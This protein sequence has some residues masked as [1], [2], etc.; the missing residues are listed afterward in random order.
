M[1]MIKKKPTT[2][3]S[4]LD[5]KV[6]KTERTAVAILTHWMREIINNKLLDLGMPDVETLADDRL[7][8]DAVIYE[9]QRSQNVLCVI[10]AKPP[11]YDVFDERALKEPA[12]KKASYRKAKYFAVTNFK[13]L[14]WYSTEKVNAL[15]PEEEQ[16][17]EKYLLSDIE[18][19]DDI[20]QTRYSK[21]FKK[22]LEDFLIRLYSVHSGKEPE[23]KLAIDDFLVFRLHQKIDVL[24]NYYGK[25]IHDQCHKDATFARQLMNW[26]LDQQWSFTWQPGDFMKAARQAAYLLV[27]KILFYDLLQAKRPKDLDPLE[28]PE[29]RTKGHLL[30]KNLEN[31]FNDVLKIDY[32]SIFTSDF[33]DSIAFP[34]VYE[35][36]EEIKSLINILRRYDFS[37]MGYDIIGRIFE[38]LI[39]MGERHS[40]GQYF[41]NPDIVD[42]ILKFC[43]NHEDDRIVDPSCGAGTFLV[44][45]Y[46]H[47]KLTNERLSHEQILETL[48]GNDIAKFPAHLAAINL[49]INDLGVDKN[50]PNILQSDFFELQVGDHGFDLSE[51]RKKRAAT[52][53]LKEREITYPRWFNAVVGNPPYTRQEEIS[54]IS[55]DDAAYKESLIENSLYFHGKKIATISKRAGIHAYFFVHGTKFLAEGGYFGFIV[56]NSWLDVDYGKGL[57]EFFLK[58][59]KII[60]II[61]SKVERWFEQADINTCIVILQKCSNE[62]E[63]NEHLARFVYL[64]RPLRE[65]IP[66]AQD[67]WEKQLERLNQID[68][69]K[70]TI[71]AHNDFYENKE[72]RIFPK[73]QRDL[74]EEGYDSEKEEYVGAK[75]GKYLRAPEIFFK[76]MQKGKDKLIPLKEIAEVRFGIKTGANEFFYLTEEEIKQKGIEQEFWMHQDEK[77]NS[78]PNYI[79]KNPR[80][81]KSIF[82]TSESFDSRILMIHKDK[83]ELKGTRI[84]NYIEEGELKGFE[85]RPTC[86]SR[87]R[88]YDLGFQNPP[89][90][91]WFKAFNDRFL[92][93]QNIEHIFSSDRFY[94]IYLKDKLLKNRLFLYLNSSLPVLFVELFGRVNLGEG[95]LDNMTY[96]VAI[97]PIVDIRTV[98]F[99]DGRSFK[100]FLNRSIE[101]IF[102]ELGA[103]SRKEVALEKVKPDRRELDKIIMGDILGLTEDEQLEV[104][105]A[106]IDLVKSRLD[107][108]K[109]FNNKKKTKIAYQFDE[110]KD[111]IVTI[112]K[113]GI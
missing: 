103:F 26:F 66:P 21:A 112:I 62:Q 67:L 53:G 25:M 79:I 11:T 95:A 113:D 38:Q 68:K 93:P 32:E 63:R 59:Y 1:N 78:I 20:E 40:L 9:S 28:I 33:I 39:P 22:G 15:K 92:A 110:V 49:A 12:R 4:P 3:P 8:P 47:K 70:R 55:P 74:W 43:L 17:F 46:Q 50:Y 90:G 109:S 91:I 10:E 65:F 45:A 75:W 72:L 14:I 83:D 34:N 87:E 111:K 27:N 106:I 48:W 41:T 30:Q 84:L 96:E 13:F 42:L 80:E 31:Y 102:E 94:G 101:T 88:W 36:V 98:N 2:N 23:P 105:R 108:A 61:E 54:E 19:L 5:M 52:L 85:K 58:N 76:I 73:C 7:M 44:R 97:M 99:H 77:G 81:C 29:T 64:K 16:I 82:I 57:Q 24:A 107:R 69:L 18:N 71:L 37:K 35:I 60:A 89:D 6:H 100:K 56:S 51:W 104:Y 86:A